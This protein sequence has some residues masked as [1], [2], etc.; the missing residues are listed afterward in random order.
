[1]LQPNAIANGC[2]LTIDRDLHPKFRVLFA[3]SNR[4]G[5]SRDALIAEDR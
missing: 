5:M 4:A 1:M 2:R 3:I